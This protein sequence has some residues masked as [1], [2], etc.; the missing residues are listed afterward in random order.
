M[1]GLEKAL[2]IESYRTFLHLRLLLASAGGKARAFMFVFLVL[3]KPQW[4]ELKDHRSQGPMET[5]P[6]EPAGT[7]KVHCH[8]G[9]HIEP[10][11]PNRL[12]YYTNA[13]LANSYRFKPRLEGSWMGH[14]RGIS[15]YFFFFFVFFLLF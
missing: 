12:V 10:E 13:R 11:G 2:D 1:T 6:T 14:T 7:E 5:V 9:M 4:H 8:C 15:S 3:A